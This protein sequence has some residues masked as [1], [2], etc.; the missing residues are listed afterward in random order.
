MGLRGNLL[1]ALGILAFSQSAFSQVASSPSATALPNPLQLFLLDGNSVT[2]TLLGHGT[3]DLF[4]RSDAGLVTF[5]FTDV[6][7]KSLIQAG[8]L[9]P[10]DPQALLQRIDQLEAII[11]ALRHQ[12]TASVGRVLSTNRPSA[13]LPSTPPVATT[14]SIQPTVDVLV[15]APSSSTSADQGSSSS[16]GDVYVNGYYRK[17]GT[18]VNGYYRRK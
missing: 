4:F 5:S 3:D 9:S 6:Q 10:T 17:N 2:G 11:T 1:L 8:L 13:V 16:S 7:S 18:Y 12:D 15:S 14:V